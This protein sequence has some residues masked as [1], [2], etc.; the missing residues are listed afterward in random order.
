MDEEMLRKTLLEYMYAG[1][2]S[3]LPAMML[4][5]DRIRNGSLEELAEIMREY[6]MTLKVTIE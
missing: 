5:E 2:F 1:A 6:G 4:D 3:G